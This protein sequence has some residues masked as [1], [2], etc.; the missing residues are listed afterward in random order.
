MESGAP[1]AAAPGQRRRAWTPGALEPL[2][3]TA[4]DVAA[5]RRPVAVV[6]DSRPPPQF[7]GEAVWFETGS[8]PADADGIARPLEATCARAC[9]V[10][11]D[12]PVGARSTGPTTRSRTARE[13]R[14][15]FAAAGVRAGCR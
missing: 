15:L 5:A 14:A 13:L 2:V 10:G 1:A 3:A 6:L 8:V 9:P 7:R 4:D 12:V 11:Q